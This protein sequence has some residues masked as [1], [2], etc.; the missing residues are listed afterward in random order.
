MEFIN[1]RQNNEQLIEDQTKIKDR[2]FFLTLYDKK[3]EL[4]IIDLSSIK[5]NDIIGKYLK[6]DKK[7]VQTLQIEFTEQIKKNKNN[8]DNI[9]EFLEENPIDNI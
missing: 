5:I 3:L 2:Q 6:D 7:K 8:L 9:I 4:E 1:Q